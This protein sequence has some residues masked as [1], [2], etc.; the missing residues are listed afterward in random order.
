MF[1]ERSSNLFYN[2]NRFDCS[3]SFAESN[4][5]P[6]FSYFFRKQSFPEYRSVLEI[7]IRTRYPLVVI[8]FF[9]TQNSYLTFFCRETTVSERAI[10]SHAYLERNVCWSTVSGH[11][12]RLHYAECR[13][14]SRLPPLWRSTVFRS[15]HR[16]RISRLSNLSKFYFK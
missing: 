8:P 3:R 11:N 10:G 6:N 1:S 12:T 2:N 7:C 4:Y 16:R 9:I 15:D 14:V 5:N 13:E